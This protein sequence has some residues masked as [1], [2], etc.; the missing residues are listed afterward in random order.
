MIPVNGI[1]TGVTML[2]EI[3]T[4]ENITCHAAS[5]AFGFKPLPE[6]LRT[7]KGLVGF[8]IVS[9]EKVAQQMFEGMTTLPPDSVKQLEMFP[10]DSLQEGPEKLM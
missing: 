4:G 7:G 3:I 9:D 6:P 5:R 8:G 10:L 1:P 2:D